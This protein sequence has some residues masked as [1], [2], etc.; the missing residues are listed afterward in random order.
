MKNIKSYDDFLNESLNESKI[1]NIVELFDFFNRMG[2]DYESV[3]ILSKL[4]VKEFK[5]FGDKG[6]IELFKE[7]TGHDIDSISKGKYVFDKI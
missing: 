7:I 1:Y 6:V 2:Y 3:K 4:L 5:R